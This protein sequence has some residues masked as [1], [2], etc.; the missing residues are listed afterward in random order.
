[1]STL[2]STLHEISLV[3]YRDLSDAAVEE[4]FEELQRASEA[5]EAERL[6]CLAELD[7]RKSYQRDGFLSTSSWI[8]HRHRIGWPKASSDVRAA[9]AL[10]EMPGVRAALA[11][12]T[13]S[14][15]A[16]RELIAARESE[17]EAWQGAEELLIDVAGQHS[18]KDLRRVIGHWRNV[19]EAGGESSGADGTS[20]RRRLHV[21]PTA[22]GMVRIDGDL[23]ALTGESV[24][25][26]LRAI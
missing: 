9:R 16:A 19:V 6:R 4:E 22:F 15:S 11:A 1:M 20:E 17:P 3:D 5:L 13:I 2:R 25:T 18:I 8:A 24:I 14:W 21:S 12:E 26:A 7:R 23:D 10:G